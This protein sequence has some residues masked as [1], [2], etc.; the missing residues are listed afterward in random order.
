MI[1]RYLVALDCAL[2]RDYLGDAVISHEGIV[3]D[4]LA[5]ALEVRRGISAILARY[6]MKTRQT[7]SVKR[8]CVIVGGGYLALGP[9]DWVAKSRARC[10]LICCWNF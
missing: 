8:N 5:C 2:P 3:C 4:T 10:R 9:S 6:H 7:P 1:S